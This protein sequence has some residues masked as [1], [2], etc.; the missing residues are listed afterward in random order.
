MREEGKSG[1][2]RKNQTKGIIL[3]VRIEADISEMY[4]KY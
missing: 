3:R 2:M 4:N 1:V